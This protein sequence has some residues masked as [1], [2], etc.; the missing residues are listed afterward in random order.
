MGKRIL[1]QSKRAY[2]KK[3]SKT[4]KINVKIVKGKTAKSSS[5]YQEYEPYDSKYSFWINALIFTITAIITI[6]FVTL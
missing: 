6:I 3:A 2:S 1:G 4:K 5:N